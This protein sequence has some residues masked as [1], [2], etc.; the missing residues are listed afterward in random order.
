V[1]WGDSWSYGE[2]GDWRAENVL[3]DAGGL[4]F[5]VKSPLGNVKVRVPMIG[6]FNV[7]NVLAALAAVSAKALELSELPELL[8]GFP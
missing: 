4:S 6:R 5:I 3:E 7:S 2:N 8:H 1:G